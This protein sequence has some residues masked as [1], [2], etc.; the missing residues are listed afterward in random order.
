MEWLEKVV[1]EA[2]K[3]GGEGLPE[4]G[5]VRWSGGACS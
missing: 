5:T 3:R 1:V 4:Y 2:S